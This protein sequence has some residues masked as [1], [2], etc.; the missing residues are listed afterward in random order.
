M[1]RDQTLK[2]HSITEKSIRPSHLFSR[3]QLLWSTESNAMQWTVSLMW[4]QILL[5]NL[6]ITST[7]L[8]CSARVPFRASVLTLLRL[9]QH[10]L[11]KHLSMIFLKLCSRTMRKQCSL[12]TLT[13]M[14]FGSLGESSCFLFFFLH[15]CLLLFDSQVKTEFLQLFSFVMTHVDL[16]LDNGLLPREDFTILLMLLQDTQLR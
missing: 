11:L 10:Q 6:L 13:V 4:T 15:W 1:Q 12:G 7:S 16:V 9:L 2:D 14:T 8:E 5:S 3:T